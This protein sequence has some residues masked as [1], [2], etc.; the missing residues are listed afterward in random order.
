MKV[1]RRWG[2]GNHPQLSYVARLVGLRSDADGEEAHALV[3]GIGHGGKYVWVSWVRDAVEEQNGHLDAGKRGLVQVDAGEVGDGV[4]GVGAV[5]DVDHGGNA[6]LEVVGA[7]P[8]IEGLL[9]DDMAAILEEGGAGDE[10][11]AGL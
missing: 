1:A 11:T 3:L 2:T 9:Y 8:L 4:G 10:S 6:G 7:P 5:T